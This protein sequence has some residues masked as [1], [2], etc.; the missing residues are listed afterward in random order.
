MSR[1]EGRTIYTNR[2]GKFVSVLA[3]RARE[4]CN[5]VIVCDYGDWSGFRT[6]AECEAQFDELLAYHRPDRFFTV[7]ER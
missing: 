1:L 5:F 6:L 3:P 7:V 2:G 4:R